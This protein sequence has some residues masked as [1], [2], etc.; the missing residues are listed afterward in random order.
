MWQK[1][2]RR[3]LS[4]GKTK[5]KRKRRK[6]EL[7]RESLHS[8]VSDSERKKTIEARG[9]TQKTR[10]ISA[11]EVNV[12]NPG[13]GETSV[14]EIN[15]VVENNAN[16]HFIR[17]N[18]ITKGAVVETNKGKVKI[19]SRPGQNGQADGIRLED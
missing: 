13:T 9:G 3:K 10:L 4:G 8:E 15:S 1:K 17:R 6:H 19:T 5:D 11:R 16:P 7:G 14:E 2:S 18:V 12:T